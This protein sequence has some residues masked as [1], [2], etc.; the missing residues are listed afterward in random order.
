LPAQPDLTAE[1]QDFRVG[2][3][4]PPGLTKH[5][6]HPDGRYVDIVITAPDGTAVPLRLMPGEQYEL[7]KA[8]GALLEGVASERVSWRHATIKVDSAGHVLLRDNGSL[9]GTFVDGK[10]LAADEW[11]RIYDGQTVMLGREFEI[12]V[13]FARQMTEL[14]LF[15][16]GGEV[17]Q[18]YRGH[19]IDVG[20][21]LVPVDAPGWN[22]V[23]ANHVKIGMDDDGQMWIEDIGSLNHTEVNGVVLAPGVRSPLRPMDSLVLGGYRGVAQFLP[24]D[25]VFDAQPVE[26]KIGGGRGVSA[27]RLAP[28]QSIPIGTASDSPFAPQLS[29]AIGVAPQH[30]RIGLDPDGR[31]W[32][33]DV[34]GSPGVWVNGDRIASDRK[35]TLTEGDV[36]GLGPNYSGPVYLDD[37]ANSEPS[38]VALH[39]ENS[40]RRPIELTPGSHTS[41]DYGDLNM[42][43]RVLDPAAVPRNIVHIGRDL[44]GRVWV[45]DPNPA[46]WNRVYVGGEQVPPDQKRYVYPGEAV[47]FGEVRAHLD[48][49]PEQPLTVRLSDDES[50]APLSLHRGER[51]VIG[52]DPDSPMS[53][54][55]AS[56]NSVSR[57][58]AEIYRD[59]SGDLW[60]IDTH[61]KRGTWV[62]NHRVDPEESGVRLQPGDRIRLGKWVGAAQFTDRYHSAAE[63]SVP[64]NLN[65]AAGTASFTLVRGGE[66]M[67]LGR[68]SRDLPPGLAE[69]KHISNAHLSI[70]AHPSG[71]VWIRDEHSKNRTFVNGIAITA[72]VK[73]TLNPGDTVRLATE[74]NDFTVAFPPPDGGPFISLL[75]RTPETLAAVADIGFLPHGIYERV[76]DHLNAMPEGGIIIGKK[77]IAEHPGLERLVRE[78]PHG[79]NDRVA[80]NNVAGLYSG[81]PRRLYVDTRM[82]SGFEPH[83]ILVMH[84]FGHAADAAYGTGGRW[85]S[86]GQEW[87]DLHTRLIEKVGGKVRWR[88]YYDVPVESFAEAFAAWVV[89]LKQLR[90]FTLGNKEIAEELKEYFDR[91]FG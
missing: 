3:I 5:Y 49:G 44:D 55:F 1:E 2:A 37:E 72:G 34:A 12:G 53:S 61:S 88:H 20:R 4:Q 86:S 14:R 21:S 82:R 89:G 28:G 80:W 33:S 22:S 36:L 8:A 18:L 6:L 50:V 67:E 74:G 83:Q 39:F 13:R 41:I 68:A 10:Q 7:G 56:D 66:P 11:A 24:P 47:R 45:H 62:E 38:V 70:G 43:V 63:K 87:Q 27:V 16:D 90:K 19:F 57:R 48:A 51:V 77:R 52:R 40:R 26:V 84:E 35:V 30:A 85:L 31:L 54:H 81:G 23:S 69:L 64:V 17:L 75:D 78:N 59:E 71:R 79:P 65:G 15:G 29:R 73:H 42:H 32:V 9:N 60:L 76:V 46:S 58:H 25:A 91:V